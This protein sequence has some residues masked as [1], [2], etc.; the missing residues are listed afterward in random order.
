MAI[1]VNSNTRIITQ[2]ITGKFGLRHTEISLNYGS[3]FVGGVTPGKG[4]QKALGLPV[5]NTVLEAKNNLNCN[6]SVIF[7]PP[8]Y[9]KDALIE[10]I[11]AQIELVVCITEGIP[12]KDMLEVKA[13]LKKSGK[14]KLIG[15]NC[16]GIVSP[17]LCR[18]G[19]MP[20]N[21]F[22]KGKLGIVSRS[23][24]LT[25]EAIFQSSKANIGQSTCIGIGG[26]PITGLDFI[27]V[28]KLF[29]EDKETNAVLMIGEIGGNLEEQ[30]CEWIKKNATKP[31]F[32][33]I[34]GRYCPEGRRMGHAGA[35]VEEG[36]GGVAAKLIALKDAGVH[37]I[38]NPHEMGITLKN[39]LD[40]NA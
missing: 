11:D 31:I 17:N 23:G 38:L 22:K 20:P 35:I 4:G 37:L 2:G 3:K 10:A 25:Y 13:F 1:L 9:A 18:I 33:Y 26:D 6:A 7:V 40:A 21:I 24:T 30:A 36:L 27:D 16:P 29:E 28:L 34:A 8:Q 39:K 19:I 15:P 32:A 14:T 12:L 5:F